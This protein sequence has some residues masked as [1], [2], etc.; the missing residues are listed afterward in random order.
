M[1]NDAVQQLDPAMRWVWLI[2]WM[3][4]VV[5]PIVVLAAVVGVFDD[6]ARELAAALVVVALV[7]AVIGVLRVRGLLR[8]TTYRFGAAALEISRGWLVQ[9]TSVVP[10]HRIQTVDQSAG[11]LLRRFG[12]VSLTLRTASASTDG[13]IPGIDATLAD[14]LRRELAAR[15][16]RDDAV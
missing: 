10:Y 3:A 9:R 11:P 4:L 16:G 1:R 8:R 5:A 2:P 6:E 15:S 7:V 14:D 13:D 12:L